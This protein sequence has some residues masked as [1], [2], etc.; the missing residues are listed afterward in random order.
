M[1]LC[2]FVFV[3]NNDLKSFWNYYCVGQPS[4]P[5]GFVAS[6]VCS[7]LYDVSTGR[8]GVCPATDDSVLPPSTR[9]AQSTHGTHSILYTVITAHTVQYLQ[10][11]N[12]IL[13]YRVH[14]VH[15]LH[16]EYSQYTQYSKCVE[17]TLH[18]NTYNILYRLHTTIQC[19]K[20]SV[21]AEYIQHIQMTVEILR[22]QPNSL[23]MLSNLNFQLCF[24]SFQYSLNVVSKPHTHVFQVD[25]TKSNLF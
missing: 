20:Y 17:Y 5:E 18:Y 9:Y 10:Y 13:P 2:V 25:N 12:Y 22:K 3:P 8:S 23:Q 6:V 1:K 14:T 19:I 4:C 7:G 21:H 16:T 24:L 11:T 15:T